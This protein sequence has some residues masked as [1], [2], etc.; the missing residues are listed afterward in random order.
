MIQRPT[1]REPTVKIQ[2]R[3]WRSWGARVEDLRVPK[4]WPPMPM[5]MRRAPRMRVV[6]AMVFY[7]Y[8]GRRR[9][10]KWV[11]WATGE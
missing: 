2:L 7:F 8:P 11:G 4:I 10:G 1:T 9:C 5:A 3:V 6:Q